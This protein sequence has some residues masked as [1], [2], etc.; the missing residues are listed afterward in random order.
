MAEQNDELQ[1][2]FDQLS[3]LAPKPA[4][5]PHPKQAFA[6]LQQ[7][8]ELVEE[9]KLSHQIRRWFVML[10]R[11][12]VFPLLAVFLFIFAFS[13][14]QVRAAAS[15]FLG[16]FRVQQ[17][18][19]ITISPQQIA[20]LEQ[21]AEQGLTPGELEIIH[22]PGQGQVVDSL[23]EAE[24]LTGLTAVRTLP[25]LG[26]AAEILTTGGGNGR[27]T[28]D[29]KGA[30]AIVEAAGG[31][32][33]LLADSLDGAEV[34]VSV[35]PGVAQNWSD[36]TSLMQTPSPVLDYPDDMEPTVLGE[37]LL[38]VLGLNTEEAH[39]LAQSIDWTSTLLLPIPRDA[40]TFSAVTVDGVNG[41]ALSSLTSED[42]VLLWQKEGRIYL[43]TGKMPMD[44][45]LELADSLQ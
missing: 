41:M 37:A 29:L 36:G 18:T 42:N 19:A 38:Q 27:F 7:H 13:F 15:E 11:K 35:Y 22:E 8:I 32:P 1:D 23:K 34:I 12:W 43:L 10:N 5:A 25:S 45:L 6:R 3:R 30:R 9:Q 28:V 16:L 40:A 39:D 24:D 17:F 2:V 33:N 21:V 4:D 26:E 20:L 14:P 31:D 44:N